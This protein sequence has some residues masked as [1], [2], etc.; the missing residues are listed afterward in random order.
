MSFFCTL[1]A[2]NPQFTVTQEDF[3]PR[4]LLT[5][6]I[7]YAKKEVHPKLSPPAVTMLERL[8]VRLRLRGQGNT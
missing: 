1:L 3:I 2:Q 7:S 4:D 8:Y 6:Y 5:A